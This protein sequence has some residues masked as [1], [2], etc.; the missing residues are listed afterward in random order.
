MKAPTQADYVKMAFILLK[1][2]EQSA[3]ARR[4]VKIICVCVCVHFGLFH[5]AWKSFRENVPKMDEVQKNS[6]GASV[7]QF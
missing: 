4:F 7:G 5:I 3:V 1:R 2:F 6:S